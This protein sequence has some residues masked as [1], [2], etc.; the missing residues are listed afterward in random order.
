M[1]G[2]VRN[3]RHAAIACMLASFF[4]AVRAGASQAIQHASD[5]PSFGLAVQAIDD[6]SK[7]NHRQRGLLVAAVFPGS[8]K[9]VHET[10]WKNIDRNFEGVF[11]V[12][13]MISSSPVGED[14]WY[15]FEIVMID[16]N[17][18]QIQRK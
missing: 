1:V 18:E 10:G 8:D 6:A 9:V 4:P 13:R 16:G 11:N 15:E 14:I 7:K 12:Y 2:F 3:A 17:V 5:S